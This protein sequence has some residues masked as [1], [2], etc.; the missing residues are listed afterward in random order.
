MRVFEYAINL[1]CA[2]YAF[3]FSVQ[4]FLGDIPSGLN[5]D[6][7][8]SAPSWIGEQYIMPARPAGKPRLYGRSISEQDDADETHQE[9]EVLGEHSLLA[10]EDQT[11]PITNYGDIHDND[12]LARSPDDFLQRAVRYSFPLTR[13]LSEKFRKSPS[14]IPVPALCNYLA[15]NLRW[16]VVR[17]LVGEVK[18][19]NLPLR[20]WVI[21]REVRVS[22]NGER[23]F[24]KPEI[25]WDATRGKI[26]G[27]QLG[28]LPQVEPK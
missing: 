15:A 26:W 2:P 6:E 14:S 1:V 17:P 20:L 13:P 27:L 18:D 7:I 25:V 10:L 19:R 28:E 22:E 11:S 16:L 9:H 24:G 23:T 4:F 21:R 8:S 5:P 3:P 12:I